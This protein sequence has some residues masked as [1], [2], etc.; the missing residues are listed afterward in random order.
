MPTEATTEHTPEQQLRYQLEVTIGAADHISALA[1]A[2]E[3]LLALQ[4][5][6]GTT[7]L[8]QN[9]RGIF[10]VSISLSAYAEEIERTVATL[11]Q[12]AAAIH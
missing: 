10:E 5:E 2:L 7:D 3:N 11:Q 8:K 4:L 12:E 6:I 9:L 1:I